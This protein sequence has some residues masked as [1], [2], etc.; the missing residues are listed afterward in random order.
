MPFIFFLTLLVALLIGGGW[1]SQFI[2]EMEGADKKAQFKSIL[3]PEIRKVNQEIATLR[4]E[5]K[6]F[7]LSS[8]LL[9]ND[10]YLFLIDTYNEKTS[11]DYAVS[12]EKLLQ[13]IDVL[14]ESLALAQA[15][16]E[17]AWG[18]S[19]FAKKAKNY[20][21]MWCYSLGCGLVP[22]DRPKGEIYEI[23]KYN[24]INESVQAYMLNL[25]RNAAYQEMRDKRHALKISGAKISGC[26][27][28]LTLNNYSERGEA[29]TK[30]LCKMINYNKWNT[31]DKKAPPENQ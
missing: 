26:E 29:Y 14:P 19:R 4:E 30:T 18:T 11:D 28:A 25:N 15:A 16:N 27:L 22:A 6:Q 3:L 31:L 9:E 8:V 21:G 23:A 24:D 1:S 12:I 20:F 7:D 17:S 10:R 5:I 13:K 2:S